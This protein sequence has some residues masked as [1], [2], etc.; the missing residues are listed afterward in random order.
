MK[1]VDVFKELLKN[2]G[3]CAKSTTTMTRLHCSRCPFS[4]K[5]R[6]NHRGQCHTWLEKI[7]SNEK[8][9]KVKVEVIIQEWLRRDYPK[10]DIVEYLL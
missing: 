1:I 6:G 4:D 9:A 8:R 7:T 10:E 2:D 3:D 5:A